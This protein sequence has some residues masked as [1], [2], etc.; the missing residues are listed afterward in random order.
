ML[1]RLF[2]ELDKDLPIHKGDIVEVVKVIRSQPKDTTGLQGIVTEISEVGIIA[3]KFPVSV[4][5]SHEWFYAEDE[6]KLVKKG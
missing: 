5:G 1:S 4:G 3:V 6:L 2:K